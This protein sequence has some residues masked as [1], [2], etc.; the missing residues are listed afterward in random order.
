MF[1]SAKNQS[2]SL[3]Y[4]HTTR[5]NCKYIK[6][7]QLLASQNKFL[8]H[9]ANTETNEQLEW[10]ISSFFSKLEQYVSWD[11]KNKY[12]NLIKN[13]SQKRPRNLDT[14]EI[15]I[16]RRVNSTRPVVSVLTSR[17]PSHSGGSAYASSGIGRQLIR[18]LREVHKNFS[19]GCA[20]FPTFLSR[21]FIKTTIPF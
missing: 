6:L 11:S 5:A 13:P 4:L 15:T 7:A 20:S 12:T 2:I 19:P 8:C 3:N 9:F 10:L 17:L 21:S 1:V 14:R 16:L 18:L